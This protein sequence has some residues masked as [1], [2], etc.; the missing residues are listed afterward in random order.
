LSSAITFATN[1]IAKHDGPAVEVRST[2]EPPPNGPPPDPTPK[3]PESPG[4]LARVQKDEHHE[5]RRN[6][7]LR[8]VEDRRHRE[9]A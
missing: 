3:A 9:K 6:D 1:R 2:S 7:D 5:D 4:V 8:G